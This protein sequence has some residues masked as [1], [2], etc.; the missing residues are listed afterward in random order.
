MTPVVNHLSQTIRERARRTIETALGRLPNVSFRR[1][2]DSEL[3]LD[4][5]DP[6]DADHD[7][8]VIIRPDQTMIVSRH[9]IGRTM[10]RTFVDEQGGRRE[11]SMPASMPELKERLDGWLSAV[12]VRHSGEEHAAHAMLMAEVEAA[13]Q[14]AASHFADDWLRGSFNLASACN[15]PMICLWTR[16][17]EVLHRFGQ[18]GDLFARGTMSAPL[19]KLLTRAADQTHVSA[20]KPT[21][22]PGIMVLIGQAPSFAIR[23]DLS[24]LDRMR[25][26]A[27]ADERD[28]KLYAA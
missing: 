20:S 17:G 9:T 5:L 21:S 10:R 14:G 13:V 22:D 6:D 25:R 23:N 28:F 16:N 26:M 3:K 15:G 7:L 8:K 2:R 24:I 11:M 27:A 12:R 18:N 19:Q 1:D 4:L